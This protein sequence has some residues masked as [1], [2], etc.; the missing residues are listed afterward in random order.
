MLKCNTCEGFVSD[1]I[2]GIGRVG[3]QLSKEDFFVGVKGVDNEGH[4]LS[5]LSLKSEGFHFFGHLR[6]RCNG[7][8]A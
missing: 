7:R 4:E 5:N 1:F 2:E 8:K 6:D 3:D